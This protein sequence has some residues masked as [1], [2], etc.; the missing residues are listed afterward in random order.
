MLEDVP[1]V[2]LVSRLDS[3]VCGRFGGGSNDAGDSLRL[4]IS[5]LVVVES[6]GLGFV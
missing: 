5:C 2:T 1:V 6:D 4:A 3:D